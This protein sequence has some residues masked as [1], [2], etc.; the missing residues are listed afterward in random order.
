VIA[1]AAEVESIFQSIS[2]W[3][4]EEIEAALKAWAKSMKLPIGKV[5]IT[6]RVA[7][8]GEEAGPA[9]YA[10]LAVLGQ[11]EVLGRWKQFMEAYVVSG[12]V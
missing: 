12:R 6:L 11:Q 5:L 8:T 2:V 7:L 3:Q 1:H 9:L 4:K 10:V